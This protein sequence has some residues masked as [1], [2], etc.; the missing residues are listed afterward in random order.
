MCI[1]PL[2]LIEITEADCGSAAEAQ[3]CR[4]L[5]EIDTSVRCLAAAHL[6]ECVIQQ[7]PVDHAAAILAAVQ[8]KGCGHRNGRR[9]RERHF[10][11]AMHVHRLARVLH[12]APHHCARFLRLLENG[13][14]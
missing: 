13:R 8:P 9:T 14:E 4:L 12:A 2:C 10:D 5:D 1:C 3:L 6:P 7:L 11:G